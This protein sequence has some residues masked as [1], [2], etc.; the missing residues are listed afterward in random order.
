MN[1]LLKQLS[2]NEIALQHIKAA[3]PDLLFVR[4][5]QDIPNISVINDG[6]AAIC[7]QCDS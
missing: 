5:Y 2:N 4:K 6:F 7:L 3:I 1:E